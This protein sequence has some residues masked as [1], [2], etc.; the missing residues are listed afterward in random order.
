MADNEK[1]L[2]ELL[3]DTCGVSITSVDDSEQHNNYTKISDSDFSKI[4]AC[5]QNIPYILKEVHDAQFYSDT[6]KV[7]YDKG[8]GTL[9][10]SSIDSNLFRANIVAPGT[11]NDITGQALL[12]KMNWTDIMKVSEVILSVYRIASVATNQYFLARF[13]KKLEAVEKRVNEIQRFLEID[14]ESQ[15][16]ADG[17]FLKET[18]NNAQYILENQA[19][20]HATL[21]TVQSI[22]RTSLANIKLFYEQLQ[23]LRLLL[24]QNDNDEE[25]TSKINIYKGYLTKYWYSVYLYEIAYY[26]EVYLSNSTDA[27]FLQNVIFEMKNI[28]DMFEESYKIISAEISKY[29]DKVKALNENIV[30]ALLMKSIGKVL[31][32]AASPSTP[33][34]N[35]GAKG[36]GM[37]LDIGGDALEKHEKS[38]KD[39][40]KQMVLA[41]LE[42]LI[43]PY[44]DLE[45]LKFQVSAVANIN[46]VYNHRIELIISEKEAYIRMSK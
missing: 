31:Q 42:A 1:N 9:Q 14:K 23:D 6:Y 20:C 12:Q 44:S 26:L 34:L 40:K 8:L 4:N 11:N 13:D 5:F 45:P 32:I 41:E 7:I 21:F 2:L 37:L 18:K 36:A 10:K 43:T 46:T 3:K 24:S 19:Y 27:F 25:T 35:V 33:L 17:Q 16:W 22:R 30:P 29:I 39:A 15:L 38:L 28:I